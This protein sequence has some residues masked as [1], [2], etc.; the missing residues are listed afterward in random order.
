MHVY[1]TDELRGSGY[2]RFSNC[3]C[4]RGADVVITSGKNECGEALMIYVI[5]GED[6][7]SYPPDGYRVS[8]EAEAEELLNA[9]LF[10]NDIEELMNI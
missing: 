1:I 7:H 5:E 6:F 8:C 10:F 4:E 3:E 2:A 9:L